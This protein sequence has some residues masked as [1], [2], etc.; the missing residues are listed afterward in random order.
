MIAKT[1]TQLQGLAAVEKISP[2]ETYPVPGVML[3]QMVEGIAEASGALAECYA[4]IKE[5]RELL[6]RADT[7]GTEILD[8]LHGAEAY[9]DKMLCSPEF[10][11]AEAALP[12]PI[13]ASQIN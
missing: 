9:I 12:E 8:R 2:T 3:R 7:V 10:Y 5:L 11:E 6:A 1:Q 4:E 13:K